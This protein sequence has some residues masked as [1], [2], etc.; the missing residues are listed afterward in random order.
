M[1]LLALS[2]VHMAAMIGALTG[3]CSIGTHVVWLKILNNATCQSC[4]EEDEVETSTHSILQSSF[5]QT[6]AE[7]SRLPYFLRTRRT[8]WSKL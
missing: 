3:H 4:K 5:R 7:A 2:K 1:G 6:K 8:G